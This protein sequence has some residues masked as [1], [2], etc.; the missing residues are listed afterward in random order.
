VPQPSVADQLGKVVSG[1]AKGEVR[2]GQR[3]M[4]EAIATAFAEGKH[5]AVTAGTGT[6][7]SF[8]Y[9][10][11]A[12]LSGKRVVV[13]TAT[14]ALQDQLAKKD[15]PIVAGSLPRRKE[16][17]RWAVLKGRANYVCKQR[18]AEME[19]GSGQG[20]F[21]DLAAAGSTPRAGSLGEE[22]GRLVEWAM[23]TETGDRADLD[24]EPRPRAWSAVSVTSEECPGARR[25]PN[26]TSCFAEKARYSASKADVVVVNMHLLGAH[27]RSG[28]AVLPEFEALV[29][30]EA[31]EF[32]DVL[33]ASLG[34]ELS[35][36]RLRALAIMARAALGAKAESKARRSAR[37]GSAP[38]D[39]A[40]KVL[41]VA[42]G[43]EEAL[44]P[45]REK[46]LPRGLGPLE[47]VAR[48]VVT[49][50]LALEGELRPAA[51]ESSGDPLAGDDRRVGP[52]RQDKAMGG[53]GDET[54]QRALR[55]LLAVERCRDELEG[56]LIADEDEVVF[57]VGGDRPVLRSAPL[58]VSNVV[59]AQ[60]F[61]KVPVVLTSATLA[62][63]TAERLGAPR[64]DVTEHDVGSPFRYKENALL[65][66]ATHLGDRRRPGA[67]EAIHD[68]I[69][70]LV[71]AAGGRTLGLFTSYRAMEQA[72]TALRARID[73]PIHMQGDLPKPALLQ[74]FA[75]EEA[76][77]LFATMGFWQGVDVPGPTLSLV[78]I[79]RL[80]FPRPDDPLIAARRE[81]AGAQGFRV[82]DLP[83]AATMLAQGAGRL[84]R[85]ASDR[86]VV[87]VLD[88]RLA[89]ATYSGYLV[90]ALPPMRR[91]R[92]RQVVLDFL[93]HL[94]D[95]GELAGIA[96][97]Q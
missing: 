35:P 23:E 49:R 47:E 73:W 87:A 11:P 74:A 97:A 78:V 88:S 61:E 28:G 64:D 12:G 46:R 15:L 39:A 44:L 94:Q 80:P 90:K 10:V 31:H 20:S 25:C 51:G 40:E 33:A 2:D 4:A 68:E 55:A 21:D 30:D 48:L 24:F 7:K 85:S 54:A 26:G 91:T 77:C 71:T 81:A 52:D 86:G 66:C 76:A 5:A 45:F 1:L 60:L 89:G 27:L 19:E 65:Y 63:G 82:V 83:R 70:A 36:G 22:V 37:S 8:A 38:D 56:L 79:D 67:E 95:P 62:P 42:I 50:L 41:A 57:V 9:L 16:P 29:V 32:E 18:I 96:V 75:G 3:L 72:A 53:T 43:F 59:R 17:F 69:E 92:D 58:D 6:G 34:V 13:A 14:K 84:I 93:R